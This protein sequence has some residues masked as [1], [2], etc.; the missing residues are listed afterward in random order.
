VEDWSGTYGDY[1]I[2][3]VGKVFPDLATTVGVERPAEPA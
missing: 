3:K 1:L 2:A